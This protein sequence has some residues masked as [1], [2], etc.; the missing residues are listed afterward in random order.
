MVRTKR[1]S[2][3]N[4]YE[5]YSWYVPNLADMFV[6]LAWLLV[7]ALIGNLLSLLFVSISGQEAGTEYA[8]LISYPVMFLPAMFYAAAKSRRRCLGRNGVKLDSNHF[9][10]VGG[11]WCALLVI[12]ATISASFCADPIS[13][14]LP[15][16]PPALEAA[17]KSMTNGTLWVNFLCVSIFAP[18]FEEWLCRGMILRGLL[19]NKMRPVWAI[20]ISALFFAVIHA[21]PWQAIPAFLLGCLFGYVYYKTGSLKLTMLMHF[22]NNTLALIVSSIAAFKDMDSW[23]Q[24]LPG[25]R[26]W[27]IFSGGILLLVLII[28]SFRKIP[29]ESAEGNCDKVPALFGDESK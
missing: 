16:M 25:E 1:P 27:M 26:Y 23:M 5:Q 29:S 3:Y 13:S 12:L 24:V 9:K 7:G 18:F 10:P 8:M 14:L 17:L 19:N 11:V 4:F 6:L 2:N 28:L 15:P 21:N 22:T 20:V